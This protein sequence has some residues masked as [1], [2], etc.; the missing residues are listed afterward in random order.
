MT[1]IQESL[2]TSRLQAWRNMLVRNASLFAWLGLILSIA[3]LFFKLGA[4]DPVSL[5]LWISSDTLFPVNVATDVLG[6]GF[7]LSGWRF[8]IAPFWFPDIFL[9]ALFWIATRNPIAA[10][11]LAGFVQPG[12]LV[13]AFLVIREAIGLGNSSLQN[14]FLLAVSVTIT[15]FVAAHPGLTY[16]DFHRFLL[17]ESHVGSLIT[18]LAALGLGLLWVRRAS[19]RTRISPAIAILYATVC[20][21]AGMSNLMFLP[22]MLAPFTAAIGFAAFFNIL[23]L[24]NC[25]RPILIG[26]PAAGV[27]AVVN[28]VVLHAAS[29]STQA[30]ISP[31]AALTALD[32][33]ARGAVNHLLALETLHVIA[34][35]WILVCLAIVAAIL[36]TLTG[37]HPER[38][39]LSQRMLC[40]F[41]TFSLLSALCCS[42]A[43]V[44]GGSN[45]LT[46]F[47][48]YNWTTHY[49][50]SI[51]FIPLFGLPMLLSWFIHRISS[52]AIS[53]ALA[54]F[55]GL[56]VLFVAAVSLVST[57]RPQTEIV[58]YR[59][60][61][62][63][64]L[65]EQASQNGLKY[66]L[67][68]YWQ[69]RLVT[70]LSSRGLRVYAV[71]GML[72]PLI[73]ASNIEW[74]SQQPGNRRQPP[75]V[76]FVI[77]DDPA[78]KISR[79]NAVRFLGEPVKELRFQ[80]TRI[81]IY[82]GAVRNVAPKAP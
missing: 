41:C 63:R 52:P 22:Q 26:W 14:V 10:T 46:D 77:L 13:V 82:A 56:V 31:N 58:N 8:S 25:W 35:T 79:E 23:A 49:L 20:V 73:W 28:R 11:L 44:V 71:D 67:G 12:L 33:F 55:M 2:K 75:P 34:C 59:P 36:R 48:D 24:R 32:V 21:L 38:V 50:Q 19:Q 65:D 60:P 78:Y 45:G 3:C 15:L 74:Y 47:K 70:L 1:A 53:A 6:D 30:K 68:G 43:I 51:F 62:V 5:K 57:P 9:S 37:Q 16:P 29:V 18:S 61:L 66:G 7:S 54:F 72:N 4:A 17:T 42:G 27:G 69:S 80:D 76:D 64:F 39:D 40:L 81:L